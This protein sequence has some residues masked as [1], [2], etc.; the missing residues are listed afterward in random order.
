MSL[1]Q[2]LLELVCHTRW[3]AWRVLTC[4]PPAYAGAYP[5]LMAAA[6]A[7]LAQVSFP[8]NQVADLCDV[9]PSVLELLGA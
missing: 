6:H 7:T 8:M 3:V 1:Q 9:P 2:C 5:A 4:C